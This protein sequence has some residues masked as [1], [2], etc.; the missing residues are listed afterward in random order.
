[1]GVDKDWVCDILTPSTE[2]TQYKHEPLMDRW[3]ERSSIHATDF[4]NFATQFYYQGHVRRLELSNPKHGFR[5]R[6]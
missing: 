6:L 2:K 3:K 4:E 5:L 1:M